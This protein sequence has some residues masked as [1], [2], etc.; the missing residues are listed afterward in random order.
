MPDCV[1]IVDDDRNILAAAKRLF[2]R[3]S[4]IS[5]LMAS[6]AG[7]AMTIV[8]GNTIPVI[9]S[10]NFMP[11]KTGIEFLEWAKVASPDSVR[12]LLTGS[13]DFQVAINSI[14]PG[15]VYRFITKPWN[16]NEFRTVVFDAL[17]RHKVVKCLKTGDEAKLFSLVRTIELKDPYTRGH[18]ERVA[19]YA[20]QIA[21][22]LH[23][24]ESE[25]INIRCGSLLHDCGKIGVP[26]A[27]LNQP[28]A[29]DGRQRE[30][31]QR[32]AQWSGEVA[33]TAGL[34]TMVIN[35]ALHHHERYDGKGYPLG[36][37]GLDIPKEARIV[38]L[39]DVYDALTSDRPY[40]KSLP[41]AKAIDHLR[42]EKNGSFDPALTDLFITTLEN[43][44]KSQNEDV[45]R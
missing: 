14:N 25:K 4:E 12:I 17:D 21:D 8:E 27:I 32:H 6:S 24:P 19:R 39:A 41:H 16:R 42:N 37:S 34:P 44:R 13:A 30:M 20:L 2:L 18:S 28:A 36:L 43:A 38:A 31:I 9:I 7:E 45:D 22:G 40:R 1:L 23:L 26:E 15:E 29:L 35:I 3:D 10:D 11:E 5:V 33:R